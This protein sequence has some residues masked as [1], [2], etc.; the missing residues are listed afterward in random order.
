MTHESPF[1]FCKVSYKSIDK[2][3]FTNDKVTES[4]SGERDDAEVER[5]TKTPLFHVRY[6]ERRKDTEEDQQR[7]D[8]YR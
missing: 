5:V 7:H 1:K 3:A 8:A 6:D 2:N 4:N